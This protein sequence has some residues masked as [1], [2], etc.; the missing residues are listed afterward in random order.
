MKSKNKI[1]KKYKNPKISEEFSAI[2]NISKKKNIILKKYNRFR[3]FRAKKKRKEN[4]LQ[5]TLFQ[6]PGGVP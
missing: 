2:D 5:S 1:I 4:A 3:S 6:K